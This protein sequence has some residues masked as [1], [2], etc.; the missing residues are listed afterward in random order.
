MVVLGGWW[1]WGDGGAGE[2]V[3]LGRWWCRGDGG[4]KRMVVPEEGV[5]ERW[6]WCWRDG[7]AG[8]MVV[9]GGWWYRGDGGAEHH[10]EKQSRTGSGWGG[11]GGTSQIG[12]NL[13]FRKS[14]TE[15]VTFEQRSRGGA[16]VKWGR[17]Q[18]ISGRG[19]SKCKDPE[20]GS[21]QDD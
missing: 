9:P 21:S 18:G 6:W 11:Q 8:E 16:G 3:V 7:R 5:P 19:N 20:A 13:S 15:K 10:G 2:L 1:C 12:L 4:A 17:G 14:F